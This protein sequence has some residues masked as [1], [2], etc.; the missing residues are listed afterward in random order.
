M[1]PTLKIIV[2]IL[3]LSLGFL[4][5]WAMKNPDT[6]GYINNKINAFQGKT[7]NREFSTKIKSANLSTDYEIEVAL[8]DIKNFDLNTIN[9]PVAIDVN[10]LTSSDFTINKHSLEKAKKLIKSIKNK[11]LNIILEPYPWIAKGSLS[12]IDWEPDNIDVFFYNWNNKILKVLIDEIAIPY[13]V[14][15]IYVGSNFE[16]MEFAEDKWA[17]TIDFVRT[18]YKG[19]VTYRTNKWD[20]AHWKPSTI[21]YY[22]NKL[23]NKLFSKLDFISIAAYFEL[24]DK[25]TTTV[26]DLVQCLG[27]TTRYDRKQNI[28][29]EIKNFHDKWNKPIFFGELGFPKTKKA[30]VEPWNAY[31]TD[32]VSSQA[33]ANCFEAYRQVFE[34]EPW[35]LGFSIFAVGERSQDKR[36]YP[37]EESKKVINEWYK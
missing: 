11:K 21:E 15:A 19:L 22:E 8:E 24:T 27:S 34:K 23:N 10:S 13:H 16:Q 7:L 35:H 6:R 25:D 12:E 2:L 1:K 9:I 17:E 31:L 33:Q 29:Q 3:I 20:T 30:S 18:Y 5:Y 26:E 36:Y 37:G 32:E 28:Y 14:D 4:T